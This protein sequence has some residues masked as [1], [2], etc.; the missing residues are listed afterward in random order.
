MAQIGIAIIGC[1]GITLQNHL[2]GLALCPDTKV[3]AL[4]DSSAEVL[5][6]ASQQTGITATYSDYNEVMKRADVSGVII[7][8]PNF[9]HAPIALAAIAAG[10]HAFCEKPIAMDFPESL[11]MFRA[12][13]KA[14]VRHMTAFTYR[15]VPAMRYMSHLVGA[16]AVGQPYHFRSC[17]LQD[18]ATRSV[19]WRQV[20]K[21]AGSG[22]LGDMLSHRIDYGHMMLGPITQLVANTRRFHDVRSGQ[23][24]DLEDWVAIIGDFTKGATGVLESSKVATGRGESARSQDYVEIN[25]SEG[26]IV[27]QLEQPQQLQITKAGET[28]LRTVPV[29]QE[30]LKWPG[31]PRDPRQGDPVFN[32]RY[33]QNFEFID[34]IRNQRPCSPSFYDGALAQ[35]V[36]DSALLSAEEKRWIDVQPMIAQLKVQL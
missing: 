28:S 19:N 18:W 1:G 16:G 13:E 27:F 7:A 20:K 22:E 3:V 9:L 23:V 2:P 35:A 5:Q 24:S 26:T 29:P 11:K 15:F 36:M 8:T 31:S 25:G 4:C 34:A 10:K 6:R 17:R 12:A 14:G 21:L 33:D 30:F 32:F